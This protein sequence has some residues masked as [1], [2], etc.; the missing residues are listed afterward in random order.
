MTGLTP[1]APVAPGAPVAPVQQPQAP[2]APV[3]PKPVKP[4]TTTPAP[5]KTEPAIDYNSSVGRENEINTNV[6]NITTS[7]PTLLKDRN[8][9]NNAF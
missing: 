3:A 7:N 9:F 2:V 8:A 1:I 5:V 4:T 6:A